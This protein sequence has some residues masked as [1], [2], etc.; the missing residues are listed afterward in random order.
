VKDVCLTLEHPEDELWLYGSGHGAF[1]ARAVAGIVHRM[2]LPR[3][4]AFDE[5]FDATIGLIKAQV[6]D[7]FKKGPQLMQKIKSEANDPPRIPFVG[8]FDTTIH[9]SRTSYDISFNQSIETVRHAL[10]MNE[11]RSQRTPEIFNIP[12]DADMT[13]RSLIQAWFLGTH[14]DVIGGTAQDG[15]SL[16]PL[17]WMILESIYSGLS[18]N[19]MGDS[20][21]SDHPMALI[22][23]QYAGSLPP[24]DGSEE[25]EWR[26][27][28]T[29]G[30]RTSMF[31]LQSTHGK[32]SAAG[33][34]IHAIK[35]DTDCYK[36]ASNRQV[37]DSHGAL[38]GWCD[39]GKRHHR[40]DQSAADNL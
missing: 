12:E 28:Y 35:L 6:E 29:N 31:D 34:D 24:L 11:N 21:D 5:L 16:Y 22:F 14:E 36:R 38:K 7:D 30:L 26:L 27:Q 32:K 37:F 3:S 15:L 19:N 4:Q 13:N 39:A 23:P 8:L 18:V 20:K 10:A 33:I 17:Q 2:G 40:M 25:I 9:T 1:I